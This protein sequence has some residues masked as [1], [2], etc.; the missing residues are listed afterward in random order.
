MIRGLSMTFI[1]LAFPAAAAAMIVAFFFFFSSFF[2]SFPQVPRGGL[3][4]P[5]FSEAADPFTRQQQQQQHQLVPL[6]SP[7][8]RLCH[9]VSQGGLT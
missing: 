4:K 9:L 6:L 5:C 8:S 7:F 1:F 2:L 3:S